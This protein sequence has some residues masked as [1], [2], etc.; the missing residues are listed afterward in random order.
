MSASRPARPF[1]GGA[2]QRGALEASQLVGNTSV[3]TNSSPYPMI[4]PPAQSWMPRGTRLVIARR[5][6]NGTR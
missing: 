2:Q 3:V 6:D 5:G 1:S 4:P